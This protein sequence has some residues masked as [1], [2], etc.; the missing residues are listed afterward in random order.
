M[1]AVNLNGETPVKAEKYSRN[2]ALKENPQVS[3]GV[4]VVR[5]SAVLGFFGVS[6]FL[7]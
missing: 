3:N 5:I 6:A 7:I 2:F 4:F 1:S